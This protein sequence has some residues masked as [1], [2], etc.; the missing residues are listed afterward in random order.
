MP[1]N[2][3][4]AYN[5]PTQPTGNDATTRLAQYGSPYA[6]NREWSP[7]PSEMGAMTLT[8]LPIG[9]RIKIRFARHPGEIFDPPC[10]SFLRPIPLLGQPTATNLTA[11]IPPKGKLLAE[12]FKPH[13]PSHLLVPRDVSMAD[14]ARFLEDL[15]VAG[16]MTGLQQVVSNVA[17]V[18][19]HLGATGYFV[20]KAIQK[21][22][23]KGKE[24]VVYEALTVWQERFFMPRGL[25]VDFER[26]NS[27]TG[28][29]SISSS[30]TSDS[31]SDSDDEGEVSGRKR[32]K[33]QR[34]RDERARKEAK[35]SAKKEK[36]EHK[37][38]DK[39][40]KRKS[41][42]SPMTLVVRVL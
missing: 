39:R 21:G 30:S 16:R 18:T 42:E 25:K 17:P 26:D 19:M 34:R 41:D 31:S 33:D 8:Q 15:E 5:Q 7:G 3:L 36:R 35:K 27:K 9:L 6:T 22:M 12:G 20:T 13:Y 24:P 10:P 38:R 23:L 4:S 14:W 32:D 40:G 29:H 1:L 2:D 37:K 11:R 28:R